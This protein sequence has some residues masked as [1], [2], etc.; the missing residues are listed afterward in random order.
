MG[1]WCFLCDRLKDET[2][3]RCS[4]RDKVTCVTCRHFQIRETGACVPVGICT[5]KIWDKIHVIE[6]DENK[7]IVCDYW[8]VKEGTY[9]CK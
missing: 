6:H 9:L 8:R 2:C 7:P 1:E 3:V 4:D 5:A